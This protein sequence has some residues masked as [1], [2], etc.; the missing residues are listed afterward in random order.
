MPVDK[1]DP[2]NIK[3]INMRG[4]GNQCPDWAVRVDRRTK[5]GNEYS[6][7]EH[8]AARFRVVSVEAAVDMYQRFQLPAQAEEARREL[9]KNTPFACW[10]CNPCHALLLWEIVNA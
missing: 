4:Y 2:R 9:P 8:S 6:H 7:L 3:V 5:W 10:G 1:Y